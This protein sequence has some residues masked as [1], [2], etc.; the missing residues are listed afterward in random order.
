MP[1]FVRATLIAAICLARSVV[2][3]PANAEAEADPATWRRLAVDSAQQSAPL[4][5]DP[6]RRTEILAG[7]AKAQIL[8]DD[9]GGAERTV[10]A[11]LEAAGAVTEP[12]F[13]GWALHEIVL[14]Q[15]A[16]ADLVGA[17]DTTARIQSRRPRGAA[18]AAIAVVQLRG[19]N[20]AQA[21]ATASRIEDTDAAGEVLRQVAM[22]QIAT[23]ARNDARATARQIDD[24]FYQAL[25]AG[26]VAVA[27]VLAGDLTS[28]YAM[29][30][31]TRR[32][33]RTQVYGR[34]AQ[35][36]ATAG[37][38]RGAM[39]TVARIDDEL[40]RPLVVARIG[41]QRAATGAHAE[42]QQL[43]SAAVTSLEQA[44]AR[45]QRK[46]TT[47]AQLARIR[48]LAEDPAGARACLGRASAGAGEVPA[49][50]QR[51]EL[52]DTIARSY[53]R[54]GDGE[55]A[56]A[57]ARSIADKVTQALLIR[58]VVA[59]QS[60][61]VKAESLARNPE[62]TKDALNETAALFGLIGVRLSKQQRSIDPSRD[63]ATTIKAA[64]HAVLEI[65]DAQIKP[66]A[67][68]ALAAASAAIGEFTMGRGIFDEALA[69]AASLESPDQR[70]LAY[71]RIVDALDRRLLFLGQPVHGDSE[72]A[73]GDG[74]Q[75]STRPR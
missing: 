56:L 60:D 73:A 69:A 74:P 50:R 22:A 27:D 48:A 61:P 26:D 19:G 72:L 75:S 46:A 55:S 36:Q 70:A 39:A 40:Y 1:H 35:A 23:G 64:H 67:L 47:W 5:S 71:V 63:V 38:V 44:P 42:A 54:L 43:F 8:I 53:I 66:A 12:T 49:G 11:A 32:A 13:Q 68:A 52:L 21:Q 18:L 62:V 3:A 15:I 41:A 58:D 10:R 45:G 33:D 17:R 14:A 7:I 30:G 31:R 37:D 65:G 29:A 51:D 24:D 59:S 57:T 9:E 4:I 34:V 25:A 20:I 28:A 2:V 6:Y 16:A